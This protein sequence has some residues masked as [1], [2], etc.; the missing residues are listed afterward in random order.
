MNPNIKEIEFNKE[1]TDIYNQLIK[2]IN[3]NLK[4]E[5]YKIIFDKDFK[6]ERIDYKM[7]GDVMKIE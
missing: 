6:L 2:C 1:Y 7:N 3:N 4:I 5:T